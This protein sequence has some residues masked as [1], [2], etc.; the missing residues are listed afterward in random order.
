MMCYTSINTI[1]VN[2]EITFKYKDMKFLGKRQNLR[3]KCNQ[4]TVT[5]FFYILLFSTWFGLYF[6][7]F[8]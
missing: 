8:D 2:L 6:V 7:D 5:P 1:L 4:F 3:S